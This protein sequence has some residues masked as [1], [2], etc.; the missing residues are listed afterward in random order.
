ML[1]VKYF[2]INKHYFQGLKELEISQEE[3]VPWRSSLAVCFQKMDKKEP[4]NSYHFTCLRND[5][6]SES[7]M[8]FLGKSHIIIGKTIAHYVQKVFTNVIAVGLGNIYLN[9]LTFSSFMRPSNWTINSLRLS[10][11]ADILCSSSSLR[12]LRKK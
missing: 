11:R 10:W 9:C 8:T 2:W 4:C 7:E 6:I 3:V 1:H 5:P 12:C